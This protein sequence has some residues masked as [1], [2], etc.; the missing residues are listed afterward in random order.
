MLQMTLVP[1]LSKY[2]LLLWRKGE[3]DWPNYLRGGGASKE[4]F[5]ACII[6][7]SIN[8]Y[9]LA[10]G[11]Y[12]SLS[13]FLLPSFFLSVLLSYSIAFVKVSCSP[14]QQRGSQVSKS[15]QTSPECEEKSF[16]KCN[17]KRALYL[18]SHSLFLSFA[19]TSKRIVNRDLFSKRP[20]R[21]GRS[22]S[23]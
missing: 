19:P 11:A 16:I 20:R 13:C 10:L 4:L 18:L 2:G 7:T 3:K 14:Q 21:R 6:S 12:R 23:Y 17:R 9:C 8:R 1:S 22:E 5:Y 15:Q